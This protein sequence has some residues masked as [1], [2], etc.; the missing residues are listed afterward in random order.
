MSVTKNNYLRRP[1]V[2]IWMP[3]KCTC[4]VSSVI[5]TNRNTYDTLEHF[6]KYDGFT[7]RG[8]LKDL[9]HF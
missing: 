2:A 1:I 9:T 8:E 5:D 6:K 7:A 3:S 4:S